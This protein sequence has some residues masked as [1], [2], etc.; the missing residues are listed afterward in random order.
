MDS[1]KLLLLG[2]AVLASVSCTS[3]GQPH[4]RPN[5]ILIMADDM[6]WGDVGF[7]GS[8]WIST[9]CLDSMAREGVV[10]SRF[11]AAA[12]LS[13]PTRASVLTGRN[14]YRTGVFSANVGILREEELTLPEILHAAGY[15][16]GHFGKWH[17]GSLTCSEADANRGREGNTK[18]YNPP[19]LHGYDQAFVTESKVP[20]WDPM[21]QPSG[22]GDGKCWDCLQEGESW[23]DYGTA[24][25]DIDGRRVTDNLD[26]DDSRVIMDRVL[27]F[28]EES[29]SAGAPFLA[30]VWFH[31]PH[32]PCVA[33]PEYAAMYQGMDELSRNYGGC[34]TAMDAQV[35]R[36]NAFLREKGLAENT[37]IFFCS[38]NGP[39]NGTP[40]EA[41]IF[42]ERKRS[43]H[44]GGVRV[45]SIAYCPGL[46]KPAVC[47]ELCSTMDYLP[48]VLEL[49][50]TALPQN[51]YTLDGSSFARA[52]LKGSST[53]GHS[54]TMLLGGQVASVNG[55]YKMYSKNG[56]FELYDIV[57]DPS[58]SSDISAAN[59]NLLETFRQETSC[60]IESCK[61]S[62][63]GAE[64]GT[65]SY[66][67]TGQKWPI[68]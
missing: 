34:I 26:G 8:S 10:L 33:G 9:P 25:W 47:D 5:V 52:L 39:E 13:S 16:T 58:E 3:A 53:S 14:P 54:V 60:F 49:T 27:P 22:R 56:R 42:R 21:K 4:H 64:Y 36:L 35:G 61:E 68:K 31:A 63:K 12:A 24:Y 29:S 18:D 44:E 66:L 7:N 67:R 20:T 45:P 2:G 48:T 23:I 17:L 37:V 59:P 30:V 19:S 50:S 46:F 51:A 41:G 65:A 15:R 6:G 43:L 57:A 55:Q 40:G 62:F 32:L 28:I 11:Y 1:N 38:D